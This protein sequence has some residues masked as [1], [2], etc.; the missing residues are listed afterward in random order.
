MAEDNK[1]MKM[2]IIILLLVIIIAAGTSFTVMRILSPGSDNSAQTAGQKD[3]IGLTYQLGEFTVNLTRSGGY[4]F[5]KTNIVV[6]ID[7]EEVIEELDKREPQI[8]D[9]I[10]STL[11]AQDMDVIEEPGGNIIKRLIKTKINDVITDGEIISVW[12]TNFVV[13]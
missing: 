4:K 10:I 6:E 3:E 13:Q 5:V 7:G 8:R 11:R 2:I 9:I 1:N 12:F